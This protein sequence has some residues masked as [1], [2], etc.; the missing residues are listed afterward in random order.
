MESVEHWDYWTRVVL[1][2][3]PWLRYIQEGVPAGEG[4]RDEADQLV[5]NVKTQLKGGT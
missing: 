5:I 4:I 3:Q 2:S 1:K